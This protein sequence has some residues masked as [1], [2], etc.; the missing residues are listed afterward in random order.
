MLTIERLTFLLETYGTDRR[1]WPR[2]ADQGLDA[3]LTTHAEARAHW[4]E[5]AAFE[6]VISAARAEPHLAEGRLT[7]LEERIVAA[8]MAG[9]RG[10]ADATMTTGNVIAWP[11]GRGTAVAGPEPAQVVR[12]AVGASRRWGIGGLLAASL[13]IG[14]TLGVYD[15]APAPQLLAGV[16]EP[17]GAPVAVASFYVDPDEEAL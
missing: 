8:A 10:R 5:A 13:A 9:D 16:S 17:S 3:F 11:G 15:L 6:R 4:T 12:Q 1:R 7:A 14:V 2:G